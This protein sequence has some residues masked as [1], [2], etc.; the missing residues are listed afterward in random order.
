MTV[1]HSIINLEPSIMCEIYLKKWVNPI[2][3]LKI[4]VPLARTISVKNLKISQIC[5]SVSPRLTLKF[6]SIQV[7]PPK[8]Y[9]VLP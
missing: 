5:I 4:V 9:Y 2:H 7:H 6:I 1:I 3:V 8:K